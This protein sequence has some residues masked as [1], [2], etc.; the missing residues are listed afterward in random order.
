MDEINAWWRKNADEGR[1][2]VR[3]RATPSARRSASCRAWTPSIGPIVC[4]GAV[5]PL[6]RVY[7]AGGVDLPPTVLVTEVDKA[8][9][10]ARDGDRAAVGRRLAPG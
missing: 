6:N 8:T 5:E 10:A 9:V 3:V 1:C 4:H 7:R 2:S